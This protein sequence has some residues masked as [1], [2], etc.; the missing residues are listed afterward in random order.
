MRDSLARVSREVVLCERCPRLRQ[1]CVEVA[2]TKAPL[3]YPE[4]AKLAARNAKSDSE[5][6][7][8][9]SKFRPEGTRIGE[10]AEGN[11]GGSAVGR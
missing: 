4:A 11:G 2:R 7:G 6:Y 5:N 10:A 8:G 3:A 1:W 9:K